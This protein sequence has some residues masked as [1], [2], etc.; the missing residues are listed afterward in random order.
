MFSSLFLFSSLFSYSSLPQVLLALVRP[1]FKTF[2]HFERILAR[3]KDRCSSTVLEE[4]K[5][6]REELTSSFPGKPLDHS[7]PRIIG[8]VEQFDIMFPFQT[9]IEAVRFAAESRLPVR[10]EEERIR[11]VPPLL[12]L[13]PLLSFF[14]SLVYFSSLLLSY[15]SLLFLQNYITRDEREAIIERVLDL[16]NLT[17]IA[18][19]LV[20]WGGTGGG[21]NPEER[22]RLR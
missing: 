21:I 7:Y 8:Y 2:L 11:R 18:G 16:L 19:A 6:K 3:W 15:F 4:E 14:I 13:P 12:F 10:E 20:G 5:K 17:S 22:K 9:V 1:L